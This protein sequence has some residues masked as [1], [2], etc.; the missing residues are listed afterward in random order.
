MSNTHIIRRKS[1]SHVNRNCE[2]HHRGDAFVSGQQA[3]II[4]IHLPFE[5]PTACQSLY[6]LA[7]GIPTV[8]LRSVAD[9]LLSG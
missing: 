7:T 3:V 4:I 8:V 6:H 2:I 9:A 1:E 5:V